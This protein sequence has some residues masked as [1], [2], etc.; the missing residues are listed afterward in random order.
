M[1]LIITLLRTSWR[2]QISLKMLFRAFAAH[3]TAII[4]LVFMFEQET[5]SA[6]IGSIH[7][8]F[9]TLHR[10]N[11]LNMQERLWLL[12]K[13]ENS[14]ENIRKPNGMPDS[15]NWMCR[16]VVTDFQALKDNMIEENRDRVVYYNSTLYHTGPAGH[17]VLSKP[18]I[19]TVAELY[20]LAYCDARV[21]TSV[22]SYGDMASVLTDKPTYVIRV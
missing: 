3:G 9:W 7:K 15:M 5:R 6:L 14:P 16:F 8:E 4:P 18:L 11:G 2:L 17:L 12:I 13:Q 20:L 21:I 22:T 19:D 1:M 10:L